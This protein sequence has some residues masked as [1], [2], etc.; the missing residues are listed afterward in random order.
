MPVTVAE[1]LRGVPG[2]HGERFAG[3]MHDGRTA[4]EID[5]PVGRETRQPHER[6]ELYVVVSGWGAS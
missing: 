4:T 5:A 1:A 6:D 3:S 2:P